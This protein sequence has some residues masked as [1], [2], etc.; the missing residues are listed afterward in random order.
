[1]VDSLSLSPV[2]GR[3]IDNSAYKQG[4]DSA[5]SKRPCSGRNVLKTAYPDVQIAVE[6]LSKLAL[7]LETVGREESVCREIDADI[8]G[9]GQIQG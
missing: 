9:L 7:S 5:V 1:M 4:K 8:G 6:L 2:L 3:K